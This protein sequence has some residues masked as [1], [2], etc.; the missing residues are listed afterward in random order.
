MA[1][2]TEHPPTADIC[3][4]LEGTYPYVRGG[5][6]SWVHQLISGL[7]DFSFSLV[8]IGGD[9]NS[10]GKAQYT[11]PDNVVHLECHYIMDPP[12]TQ[13]KTPGRHKHRAFSEVAR[14]HE[15]MQNTGCPLHQDQIGPLIDLLLDPQGISYDDLIHGKQ[16]WQQ[17]RNQY[18]EACTAPAFTHY[19]WTVRTIHGPIFKL[20]EI[21]AE[22]PLARVY[23]AISTGYAGFLGTMLHRLHQRPFFITEHGI[24]TKEREI[25]L[26]Q[27]SWI[28]EEEKFL[29][30][31]IDARMSYLR[32]LWM[33]FFHTLGRMAYGSANPII[34][35]YGG[36]RERQIKDGAP[37]G[38]TKV[39][40]NGINLT[41][42]SALRRP[43]DADIPP[44][45]GLIGRIV[46]IKDIK[47]FIRALRIICNQ[48]P[49][50]QGWLVGPEEEDPEYVHEC[51]MLVQNLGLT[52]NVKFLGFQKLE[53][54][55]P[56][57][58]LMVLTSISEGQPLVVLEGFAAGIPV[59]TTDVGSCR[60]LVEGGKLEDRQLGAAGRVVPIANPGETAAACLDLISDPKVWYQAQKTAIA[61][62]EKFY[63]ETQ[64]FERYHH[65]YTDILAQSSAELSTPYLEPASRG[66]R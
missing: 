35:L 42:L 28:P 19:F 64:L 14:Q 40:P 8:F 55:L 24:Y 59:V 57:L 18:F 37:S 41:T 63:N 66:D 32:E 65:I 52:N 29:D 34:S 7:P 20:A 2:K 4:L 38:Q 50:T 30:T 44:V 3:L 23:H 45:L 27:V 51:K 25:D 6:S 15:A 53:D 62:V 12:K 9:R 49:E 46:P 60:E 58:G 11:L 39:I 48:Q 17:I 33:R 10:Y 1:I 21:A 61:R 16:A 22:I 56:K 47:T 26:A 54:I 36:N 13:G 5:V 43:H 31:G